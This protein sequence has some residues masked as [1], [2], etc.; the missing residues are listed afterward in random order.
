MASS[1][2]STSGL[3]SSSSHKCDVN[4][5]DF[6]MGGTEE[7][8]HPAK[9]RKRT[10]GT[11]FINNMRNL[12]EQRKQTGADV[13]EVVRTLWQ[14]YVEHGQ[15]QPQHD[16][17]SGTGNEYPTAEEFHLSFISKVFDYFKKSDHAK[18]TTTQTYTMP[19]PA[20]SGAVGF[21]SSSSSSCAPHPQ[22]LHPMGGPPSGLS[23]FV[24][25]QQH[26][27][28]PI[29]S[30]S[31]FSHSYF[32]QEGVPNT[33]PGEDAFILPPPTSVQGGGEA[34][35]QLLSISQHSQP[36][37]GDSSSGPLSRPSLVEGDMSAEPASEPQGASPGQENLDAAQQGPS[38]S[39]SALSLEPLPKYADFP[40]YYEKS[41]RKDQKME[42]LKA[43]KS[44]IYNLHEKAMDSG[45]YYYILY[46]YTR[47]P[48]NDQC[49]YCD[50]KKTLPEEIQ[51]VASENGRR[52]YSDDFY[53]LL[54]TVHNA[55]KHVNQ[56]TPE[57]QLVHAY[58]KSLSWLKE[59][60]QKKKPEWKPSSHELDDCAAHI[61]F[62]L[63]HEQPDFIQEVVR[64]SNE[65]HRIQERERE[66]ETNKA[67]SPDACLLI[68]PFGKVG[69]DNGYSEL[70][71]WVKMG[72]VSKVEA[73]IKAGIDLTWRNG[74]QET[75]LET[76]QFLA[77]RYPVSTDV[78]ANKEEEHEEEDRRYAESIVKIVKLLE[79]AHAAEHQ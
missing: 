41:S 69:A 68:W 17:K 43:A 39:S 56:K 33:S 47:E 15:A 64:V 3:P 11:N 32:M 48:G 58:P 20:P 49:S 28:A 60:A 23:G 14:M 57:G 55:I 27:A 35:Q 59:F 54:S 30:Q 53:G 63:V 25:F 40:R 26:H 37:R 78:P 16:T 45:L 44:A 7:E 1:S 62:Y 74:Y 31:A 36:A 22:Q 73:C 13:G 76:A 72:S 52:A 24:P 19:P 42:V 34:E 6:Q 71:R 79:D 75:A 29:V 9:R 61:V 50:W 77:R 67:I 46:N 12:V 38:Q 66:R 51:N 5:E 10:S 2:S 21:L 8:A 70:H 18:T 65:C 4:T